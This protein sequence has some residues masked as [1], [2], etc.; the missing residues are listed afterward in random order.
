M[1]LVTYGSKA[2]KWHETVDKPHSFP[3]EGVSA[4]VLSWIVSPLLSGIVSVAFFWFARTFILRSDDSYSRSF[5]FLPMLVF[6]C[7]FINAFYVLDKGVASQC[8]PLLQFC[9]PLSRA[10][11]FMRMFM[12]VAGATAMHVHVHAGVR[13]YC[14]RVPVL[15]SHSR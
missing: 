8:V 5:Y 7:V 15:R 3:M 11:H 9:A 2:V 12:L 4:V 10:A 14:N 13:C 1:G 6:V